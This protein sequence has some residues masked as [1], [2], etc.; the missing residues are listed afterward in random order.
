MLPNTRERE[1]PMRPLPNCAWRF[2]VLNR[3]KACAS[4]SIFLPEKV[5]ALLKR[6]SMMLIRELSICASPM[7]ARPFCARHVFTAAR[8]R[9]R[10]PELRVV[11][12]TRSV[13][14]PSPLRSRPA[15]ADHG[16]G[17][18]AVQTT[19]SVRS[20]GSRNDPLA[21]TACRRSPFDGPKSYDVNAS[22][23]RASGA[24]SRLFVYV[25]EAMY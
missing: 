22:M 3:L 7:G 9:S 1:L 17:E 24:L 12:A 4:T 15:V 6:A 2:F 25:Y 19:P 16:S 23:Y 20:H 11:P 18:R 13:L 8:F 10:L 14:N 5:N 21:T